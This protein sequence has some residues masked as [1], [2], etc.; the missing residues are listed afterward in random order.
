MVRRR[1]RTDPAVAQLIRER[2]AH[3]LAEDAPRR[4]RPALAPAGRIDD[5]RAPVFDP[6]TPFAAAAESGHAARSE[7][8]TEDRLGKHR[9]GGG[10]LEGDGVDADGVDGDSSD[11]DVLDQDVLDD[12]LRHD[13]WTPRPR[14]QAFGRTHVGV[15]VGVILV[16]LLVAGWAV[17]RARPVPMASPLTTTPGPASA[18]APPAS[19]RST[20]A[21]TPGAT[22]MVHVL[23]A[24]RDPGVVSLAGGKRV[25]D[26][27]K[28]A[29]GLRSNAA[30]G[31]L[32]LAQRLSDGQQIVIGTTK[33]PA[34]HVR[35]GS[36]PMGGHPTNGTSRSMDAVD[37]NSATGAQL[38][39]LPGV[40]PVTAAKIISWRT[41]HGRFSRVEE[42]QEVDGIGAKTY[43]EIAPHVRV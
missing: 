1:D 35:E 40:G 38:E 16:G 19:T 30:P 8:L 26:A 6:I 25:R 29:G 11:K 23:G 18:T 22:M 15:V 24:V 14:R 31:E 5:A 21:P 3:L 32:N 28:A 34:G 27:I 17:L 4:A 13:Q 7:R 39:A 42:L 2:L 41:E 33:N 36:Q 20:S 37:L 9:L 10:G 12:H 43:A